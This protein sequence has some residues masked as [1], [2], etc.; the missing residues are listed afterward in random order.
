MIH[1]PFAQALGSRDDGRSFSC[2]REGHEK[3]SRRSSRPDVEFRIRRRQPVTIAL[4]D[5][6]TACLSDREALES[7]EA[8]G[9]EFSVL[10]M[11]STLDGRGASALRCQNERAVGERL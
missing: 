10:G 8:V 11:Q 6:A 5:E 3:P 9:Q 2:R 1:R 4:D 7:V